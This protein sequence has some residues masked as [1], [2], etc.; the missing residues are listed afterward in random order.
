MRTFKIYSLSN[1]EICST[2]L[3]IVTMLSIIS[4][5]LI[6]FITVSF[7]F[8]T[9]SLISPTPQNF[10]TFKK[11]S[12]CSKRL[13]TTILKLLVVVCKRFVKIWGTGFG[14]KKQKTCL[15]FLYWSPS[16][17]KGNTVIKNSNV[18]HLEIFYSGEKFI[19]RRYLN[20]KGEIASKS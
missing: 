15:S 2:L 5:L 1:F 17:G 14:G 16:T 9:P 20:K 7:Y 11:L 12:F 10:C 6:Y 4:P 18:K 3:T 8:W 19:N 13:G